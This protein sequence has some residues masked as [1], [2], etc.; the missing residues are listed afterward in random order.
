MNCFIAISQEADVLAAVPDKFPDH[1]F[2]IQHGVWA[3]AAAN[4]TS[5][6]ICNA[7]GINNDS[8]RAGVVV[9][10]SAYNG[11]FANTLWEKLQL[12]EAL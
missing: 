1:H 11:Y 4:K 9:G 7:L 2:E 6:D 12:W 3:V 10:A 8:K 5:G